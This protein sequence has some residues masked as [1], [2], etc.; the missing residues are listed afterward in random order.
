MALI[1]NLF[2]R[3]IVV[4]TVFTIFILTLTIIMIGARAPYY[5]DEA[6]YRYAGL[7]Y[8]QGMCPLDFN[9]EHPP[10][11]KYLFGLVG[12][13][14]MVN[15][16]ILS[17]FSSLIVL[18]MITL[19]WDG[20]RGFFAGMLLAMDVVFVNLSRHT[21]LEPVGGMF[22]VAMFFAGLYI[23]KGLQ[24][25]NSSKVGNWWYM[26]FGLLASMTIYT[27]YIFLYVAAP[28]LI[29]LLYYIWKYRGFRSV[30]VFLVTVILIFAA[31]LPLM[32]MECLPR[33]GITGTLNRLWATRSLY[34]GMHTPNPVISGIGFIHEFFRVEVWR[35][36]NTTFYYNASSHSISAGN[37]TRMG[38]FVRFDGGEFSPHNV[39]WL[40]LLLYG[41]WLVLSSKRR[42]SEFIY[43]Y[44][45]ML[46]SMLVF[47]HEPLAWYY[48]AASIMFALFFS[49][50]CCPSGR[51]RDI[52]LTVL[53]ADA[54]YIALYSLLV[55]SSFGIS[56]YIT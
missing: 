36:Y 5:G 23:L 1:N 8:V 45:V 46:G 24:S 21:M 44:T 22:V 28:S 2:H 9:G 19:L 55:H 56:F 34:E 42:D 37:F 12:T 20:K 13:V 49:S 10:L 26:L 27:K 25:R 6:I 39:L 43:L 47:I 41:G 40:P 14:F 16:K 29:I 33:Y 48:Y 7:R 35:L 15:P 18:A 17:I 54:L 4:F 52:C 53:V 30:V 38:W 31:L 3:F 50:L 32:Y 11:A 51:I